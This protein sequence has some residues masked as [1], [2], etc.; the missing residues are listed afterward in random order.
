MA[1]FTMPE[2][3]VIRKRACR[4]PTSQVR[5]HPGLSNSA[6]YR[7]EASSDPRIVED[8]PLSVDRDIGG[9][10]AVRGLVA[11]HLVIGA[12]AK[13][14]VALAVRPHAE[15]GYRDPGRDQLD[16]TATLEQTVAEDRHQIGH[17]R[18][19]KIAVECL[20]QR[21]RVAAP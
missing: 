1:G 19:T 5:A 11:E 18:E 10:A 9:E 14:R 13:E 21:R 17:R 2:M 7:S 20:V 16:R 3:D 12:G 6:R 8:E 4:F 15:V